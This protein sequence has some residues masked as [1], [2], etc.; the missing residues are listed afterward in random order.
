M[1]EKSSIPM[2]AW[3]ATHSEPA[4]EQVEHWFTYHA[5][6]PE[7]IHKIN[8]IR[9]SAKSIA[10]IITDFAPAC[11]DRSAALRKLREAVMTANAAIILE[12]K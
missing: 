7:Q 10:H 5:P 8:V 12:G 9:A 3:N 4:H 1:T 11:S 2:A 6:T